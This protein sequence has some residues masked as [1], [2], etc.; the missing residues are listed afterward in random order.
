LIKGDDQ[1][2]SSFFIILCI[3]ENE[4]EGLREDI[5]LLQDD[6]DKVKNHQIHI[7]MIDWLIELKYGRLGSKGGGY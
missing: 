6:I 3:S 2:M 4:K 7:I 5:K 1:N